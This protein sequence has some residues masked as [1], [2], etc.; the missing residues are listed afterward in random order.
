M[1]ASELCSNLH[2]VTPLSSGIS[3]LE[4]KGIAYDSRKVG[5]GYLFVAI[6]GALT[7]GH[8]YLNQAKQNGA[9]AAVVEKSDLAVAIPQIF[10]K[11]SRA[12]LS[13][14]SATWFH[15]PAK[16]LCL[17]G[18]TASNGKTT[19]AMML[20]HIL[21]ACKR[22]PA[23]LGTILYRIKD[24]TIAADL[25]TPE[26]L[27]LHGLLRKAVDAGLQS[28]VMEVSSISI[29]Q[30]RVADIK[31]DVVCFNNITREHIDQHGTFERYVEVKTRLIREASDSTVAVLGIDD[32]LVC[33]LK[34]R[35]KAKVLTFGITS[36]DADLLA[37][38]LDLSSGFGIFDL[39]IRNEI[40]TLN[41][42]VRPARIPIRL[43]VP[44]MSSVYNALS[45][46]GM[47]LAQGICPED[48]ARAISSYEG[49]ERRFQRVYAG[50]FQIYDDHYGNA[51]NVRMTLSTLE[52]MTMN[53][54]HL[55]FAVR[56][57]RGVTVNREIAEEMAHWKNRLPWSTF[58]VSLS[59]DV[60][61]PKDDVKDEETAALISTLRRAGYDPVIRETLKET[62][63]EIVAAA[64]PGDVVVLGGAQGMDPGARIAL[65]AIL[66]RYPDLDKE[67][68]MK[69][70][71][72]RI[73]G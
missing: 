32:P 10:V 33:T 15:H 71:E 28:A 54:L 62:M 43:S 47:A 46:L 58:L 6:P 16:S 29:E 59:R 64:K 8:L 1:L 39:V 7:D 3:K 21:R 18:I 19:T 4:I 12:A 17:T 60:T 44:G 63:E 61:G 24:L 73:C 34:D 14:L 42:T 50:P 5:P 41:G 36:D 9:I 51:G 45:A 55:A 56:G 35:T 65:E 26:S 53:R 38:R 37:D 68:I 57:N 48:A 23:L 40:P 70:L 69:P 66:R 27:E 52:K 30:C 13:T 2:T 67:E 49:V 72:G 20:D 22:E 25:T 11:D 31:F